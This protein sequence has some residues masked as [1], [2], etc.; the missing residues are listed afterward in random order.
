MTMKFTSREKETT[1]IGTS[2]KGSDLMAKFAPNNR[3]WTCSICL[4]SN[5][6]CMAVCVACGTAKLADDTRSVSEAPK[7]GFHL[8]NQATTSSAPNTVCGGLQGNRSSGSPFTSGKSDARSV[9]SS[10][11]KFGISDSGPRNSSPFTFGSNNSGPVNSSPFTFG[12]NNSGSVS[13]SPFT[14]G[15]NNSGSV[16]SSPFTFAMSDTGTTKSST[17]VKSH[18][19]TVNGSAFTFGKTDAGTVSSSPFTFS[20]SPSTRDDTSALEKASDT[21]CQADFSGSELLKPFPNSD[22]AWLWTTLS[23]FSDEVA[24]AETLGAR[25]KT[26]QIATEFKDTFDKALQSLKS[27]GENI[28]SS[29]KPEGK[30]TDHGTGQKRED[31]ILLVFERRVT[32]DQKERAKRLELPSNFFA[33]EDSSCESDSRQSETV[34]RLV[35]TCQDKQ[36]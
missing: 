14:F 20:A 29:A 24:A 19:K 32:D 25:F 34:A 8:L 28:A 31:D 27:E 4:V 2:K 15:S 36:C 26:S 3:S 11:F 7:T 1:T 10:P 18:T 9:T 35:R 6:E 13:S 21:A 12:S 5:D 30:E 33:Y 16:N 23:D 17:F 22:R